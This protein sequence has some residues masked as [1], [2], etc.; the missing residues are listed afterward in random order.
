MNRSFLGSSVA[1]S[2]VAIGSLSGCGGGSGSSSPSTAGPVSVQVS[3]TSPFSSSCG[4]TAAAGEV[5]TLGSGVQPQIAA[6]P[7]GALVGVWE[8]DRWSGLGTRGILTARSGDGGTTWSAAQA[9]GFSKCAAMTGPG[10]GYDRASDPWVTFA[11]S[12]VMYASALAF[13]ANGFEASG[14]LSAVLV[15][16]STDGGATWGTPIA[17]WTDTNP[18]TTSPFYFNDRDSITGDPASGNAY[19]VWARLTDAGALSRPAYL[20]LWTTASATWSTR[21]LYDPGVTNGI[22]N[23]TLN[24][25]IVILPSGV[26]LDFFTLLTLSTGTATLQVVR[27]TD[28]GATWST[29]PV[30]V[31]SVPSVGTGN[32][33]A[34]S[35]ATIRDSANMAQVAVDPASGAIAAVWQQSFGSATF[36]GIALSVSKDGGATW[37]AT[38]KQI[39]GAKTVAAFNP[40]V[41]YLPGGVLAVTYY[42][43]RDYVAGT[44][45]LSTSAWLTE[46]A[47]GGA[48]WHELRLQSPFDLTKAPP[49]AHGF[50]TGLFLGDNQG[51]ALVGSN[52]LPFY[53]AT[54]SAGAHAYAT[55]AP[56]P[57]TSSTAHVYAASQAPGVLPAVVAARARASVE[58]IRARTTPPPQP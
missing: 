17:V 33:I 12:G 25:E 15:A 31:A 53:A 49:A 30:T 44:S 28:Q 36:D 1:L 26:V 4:N 40:T 45:V 22:G 46:S 14:G 9:L 48:T 18:G 41:R 7:G 39:N 16:R 52:A 23:E 51:L 19:L 43:F 32:P 38:P 27:S 56:S 29:A 57:L 55:Q 5:F 13:S 8:Q 35:T 50:G 54:N 2:L 42:D 47:D 6:I 10:A 58:R 3:G 20:A 24:N 37:S 34:G 11:G 21:V